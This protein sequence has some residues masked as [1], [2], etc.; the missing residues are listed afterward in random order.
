MA[1]LSIGD[2]VSDVSG[3]HEGRLIDID[4]ET[5]YVM[6]ANGVEIEFPLAKLKPYEEPDAK[7]SVSVA[8]QPHGPTLNLIQRRLLASVPDEIRRAVAQSYEKG[9]D[10]G[11]RQ[12]FA[13]LPDDK[14][15]ETIRI[16]LPSLPR[17]LLSPHL[18]LVVA[19][20]DMAKDVAPRGESRHTRRA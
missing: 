11:P 16:Y 7:A 9:A 18:K 13:D 4:G 2:R 19:F 14:K 5:A 10:G 6:Q 17:H 3:A 8:G 1:R 20:R 15:L 12:A